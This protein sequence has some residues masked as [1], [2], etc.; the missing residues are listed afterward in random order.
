MPLVTIVSPSRPMSGRIRFVEAAVGEEST[1]LDDQ[2]NIVDTIGFGDV[3]RPRVGV[4]DQEQSG[5]TALHVPFGGS[6]RVWVIPERRR[7]LADRPRRFP[8][9]AGFDGLVRAAVVS[10]G[11]MHAVPMDG[12]GLCQ[13]VVDRECDRF[14]A[15][16]ADGR[17]QNGSVETPSVGEFSRDDLG[18]PGTGTKCEVANT[19][20]VDG[21]FG[22][23]RNR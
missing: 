14:S 22:K 3:Q 7:R 15:F 23:R 11:Q 17:P 10:G 2:R 13:C 5:E 21:G 4:V 16:G 9:S 1:I 20:V 12:R 6:V 8:A 18:G 19:G